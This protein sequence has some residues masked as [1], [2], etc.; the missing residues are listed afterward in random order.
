[1]VLPKY[2]IGI[3]LNRELCFVNGIIPFT[4]TDIASFAS[5]KYIPYSYCWKKV[6]D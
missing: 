4:L 1:M 6:K 3:P 2:G 5:L